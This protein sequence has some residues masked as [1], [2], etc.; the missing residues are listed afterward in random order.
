MAIV[1]VVPL[2]AANTNVDAVR[3]AAP[4]DNGAPRRRKR[5]R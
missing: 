3:K 2:V 5:S 4:V 1:P